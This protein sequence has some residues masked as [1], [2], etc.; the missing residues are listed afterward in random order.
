MLS[1][2]LR[3]Y[4]ADQTMDHLAGT[5]KKGGIKDLLA[6]FPPQKHTPQALETYFKSENLPQIAEWFTK[7]Q[8]AAIKDGLTSGLRER[9]QQDQPVEDVMSS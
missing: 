5:L 6:F 4:L 1:I 3:A 2:I 7:R 9:C 8:Y